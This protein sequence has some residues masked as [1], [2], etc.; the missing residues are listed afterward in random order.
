MAAIRAAISLSI[1][2]V[3]LVS[4]DSNEVTSDP[5]LATCV[6]GIGRLRGLTASI[7]WECLTNDAE[8]LGPMWPLKKHAKLPILNFQVNRSGNACDRSG[9]TTVLPISSAAI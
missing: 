1:S 5:R 7:I 2:V 9:F 8:Y 4:P 6:S 3:T